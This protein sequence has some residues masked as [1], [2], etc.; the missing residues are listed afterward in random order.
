[1]I[2]L[3]KKE[4]KE[5]F[6]NLNRII[7]TPDSNGKRAGI[8]MIET[9]RGSGKTTAICEKALHDFLHNGHECVFV[10]RTKDEMSSTL[11][12]FDDIFY[13]C[14]ETAPKKSLTM[15]QIVRNVVTTVFYNDKP[16][17]HSVCLKDIDKLKKLSPYFMNVSMMVFDEFQTE[18]APYLKNEP[19]LLWALHTTIN[20][21]KGLRNR[22]VRC[23]MLSNHISILNPY[24][25]YF[26]VTK[27]IQSNTRFIRGDGWIINI[28]YN[29]Y[30]AEEM[31]EGAFQKAMQSGVI[32]T[33][34]K[35][36]AA[37]F[38]F[39]NDD[40]KFIGRPKGKYKY[41][42][43]ILHNGVYYG[44]LEFFEEGVIYVSH[45]LYNPSC[46]TVLTFNPTDH[47]ENTLMLRRNS[48][49]FKVL[50]DAFDRNYLMLE[51]GIEKNAVFD[52]LGIA[53]FS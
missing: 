36:Y 50:Q 33:R 29:N 40:S 28:D 23:F 27:R 35:E 8:I 44:V 48:W 3:E 42:C 37:G 38:G 22:G 51:G 24:Y 19:E 45:S 20:R 2:E 31:N 13:R 43:S 21:G 26:G 5:K 10:Y 14:P 41:I 49:A 52:I 6:I 15:K 11:Y 30:A 39:L 53:F 7:N 47:G 46:Y 18:K 25:V 16:F 4:T 12:L 32:N 9:N 34:Y 1:M 17:C